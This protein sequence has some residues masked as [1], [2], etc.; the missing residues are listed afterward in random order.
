MKQVMKLNVNGVIYEEE[1]EEEEGEGNS[2]GRKMPIRQVMLELER[3]GI[4]QIY[5]DRWGKVRIRITGG[6]S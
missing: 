4:I 2:Y 6:W 5:E 3:D 1:I